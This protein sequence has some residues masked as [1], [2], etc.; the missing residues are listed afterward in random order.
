MFDRDDGSLL[1]AI[2]MLFEE[3][4][5]YHSSTIITSEFTITMILPGTT[6][7]KL[8]NKQ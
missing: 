2:I 1:L 4:C 8:Y 5:T 7:I 6:V 3:R